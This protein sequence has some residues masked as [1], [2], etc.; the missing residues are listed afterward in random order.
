MTSQSEKRKKAEKK[1]NNEMAIVTYFIIFLFLVMSAYI[2]FFVTNDSEK[3]LNNSYNPRQELL[4]MRVNKGKIKSQDGKVLA[5][6]VVDSKG[7]DKREYPYNGLFAHVVGRSER[8]KTG[9]EASES[10]QM[11]T[12]NINP[13][14]SMINRI[15]GDKDPGNNVVT[16]INV[17]LSQ[18]ASEA[19]GDRK[20]AVIAMD[21]TNGKILCMVSKP[22]Y[23]PNNLTDKYW[24]RLIE[25]KGENSALYNRA[26]QGLYPPGSTFKLYT[27]L[28]YIREHDESTKYNYVCRGSTQ[29][30][31]DKINCF[32][33]EVHGN[34]N[35]K[36]AFAKSCNSAFCDIGTKLN[37]S[38]WVKTCES[39]YFNKELPIDKLE[40]KQS[41]ITLSSDTR[42]G[43]VMQTSIG[44]GSTTVTPL[45]NIFMA[46][47][48]ANDGIIMK[49]YVVD[50]IEDDFSNVI[51]KT[52]PKRLVTPL[53]KK[54]S[55]Q[56]RRLMRATVTEGTATRLHYSGAYKAF[57][58][59]GSAEFQNG[60]NDSHAWFVGFAEYNGQKLAVSIVVEASGTG[61]GVAVPIAEKIFDAYW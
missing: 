37:P 23:N 49:P 45:Q 46:A 7:K 56:L 10:Y 39:F 58:K 21:P 9:L 13:I 28:E 40:K 22:T 31:Q 6:T 24:N 12:T 25:D 15:K 47:A 26:T 55:K 1:L 52:E 48:V 18:V 36:T 34:V 35:L 51:S 27:T 3:V 14:S 59:T 2:V 41:S 30:G 32:N 42:I 29:K 19:L 54:E 57:G 16:T 5:K 38:K 60:S 11:L 53:T 43:D 33:G 4:A 50:R 20:G 61:G 17:R 44:Q 8:G